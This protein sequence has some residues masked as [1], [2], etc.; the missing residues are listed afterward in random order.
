MIGY[1]F[2]VIWA[3]VFVVMGR[4]LIDAWRDLED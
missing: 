4:K 2:V 1:I 3:V